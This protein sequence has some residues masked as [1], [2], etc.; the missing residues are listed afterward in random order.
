M[1]SMAPPAVVAVACPKHM[2]FGP[3]GGVEADGGCEVGDRRCPFVG[4]ETV[5]WM[6]GTPRLARADPL[7]EARHGRPLVVVDLPEPALDATGTRRAAAALAGVVDAVLFG[8]TGWARVQYP[9]SYRAALVAMEGVRPWAG[10]NC[11]DRNRV[12]LEGELAALADI[13]AAVHCITGDHTTRGHR[14]DAA[15]VFDLDST[16]LV[17]LA[18]DAGVLCSVAENPVAPPVERRA[19]RLAEKVKAGARVCFVNHAGTAAR[20]A[21]FIDAA[22]RAGAGDVAYLVCVP[23]VCSASS[24]AL[25]RTFTGLE[26]PPGFVQRIGDARDPAVAGIDEAVR[27]AGAVLALPRVAG[28]DVGTAV[29]PGDEAAALTAVTTV[30]RSLRAA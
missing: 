6:G 24:L 13:G 30:V 20:V 18:R 26:L 3:C 25:L 14:P 7:L 4:R 10:L 12:A 1:T 27:F 19:T 17:S 2:T 9:P 22:D 15:P 8:D 23:L 16:Q 21:A 5:A 11:R 28:I 29:P